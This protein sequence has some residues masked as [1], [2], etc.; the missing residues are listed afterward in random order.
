MIP[1]GPSISG[2]LHLKQFNKLFFITGISINEISDI[3]TEDNGAYLKYRNINKFYYCNNDRT[4]I[5]REDI[6][7][8]FY[9]N[10]RLPQNS[11]KKVCIPSDKIVKLNCTYTKT[12]R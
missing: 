10:E 1:K 5:V 9:Y 11:Y 3:N 8:K 7:G 6:S 4:I 12:K 2:N